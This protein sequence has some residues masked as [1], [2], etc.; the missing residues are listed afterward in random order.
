MDEWISKKDLLRETGISYG[1]L[2]RWKRE[3]LIP[4]NW[5]DK[6]S[7]FTG[8]E[9]YLPRELILERVRFILDNKDRY[10]LTEL[11]NLLSPDSVSRCYSLRNVADAAGT[12][13]SALFYEAAYG[14]A[15]LNHGQA[16]AVLICSDY[17]RAC[18]PDDRSLSR[19]LTTLY[20]WQEG[21]LFSRS[22]GH[23]YVLRDGEDA[24]PLYCGADGELLLPEE[25]RVEYSLSMNEIART[26]TRRLN[27]IREVN[28]YGK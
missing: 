20:R 14:K 24:L 27:D 11:K 1:Q 6:R 18:H 17:D 12:A 13:R 7:S 9:T 16:V 23:I 5:F 25:A 19:F 2:Y 15:Q 8:Q 26:F 3:R 28:R 21:G 22:A 4:E 10:S